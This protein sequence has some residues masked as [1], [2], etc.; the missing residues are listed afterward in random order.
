MAF[1]IP[2]YGMTIW[3]RLDFR[4]IESSRKQEIVEQ[5]PIV[6]V[7]NFK[8]YRGKSEKLVIEEAEI[9]SGS[10]IAIIGDNG[11]GKSTF[12]LSLMQLLRTS[13]EY[14]VNGERVDVEKKKRT[15]PTGLS[16]VFQNPELQFVTN[17]VLDEIAFSYKM[18]GLSD[19]EIRREVMKLLD[20]FHIHV[21]EARHPFQL[22]M[23]QKRRLSVATAFAQGS[24]CAF[25]G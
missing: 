5:N 13:G 25:I 11:A 14:E 24:E 4:M 9:N 16:L 22:S 6:K 12:L 18:A 23:G 20:L 21:E 7:R 19:P 15:P 8:G 17:S 10:W 1:G 2:K 3:I